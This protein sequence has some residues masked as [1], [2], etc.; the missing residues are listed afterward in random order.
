[1]KSNEVEPLIKLRGVKKHFLKKSSFLEKK[2]AGKKDQTVYAV[3]G[4]NLDIRPKETLSIVGESG[5]GKSTLGRA[6]IRLHEITD[7]KILYRNEDISKFDNNELKSFRQ[8]AQIIFQNPYASLNPRKT[9]REIIQVALQSRGVT[10]F[11]DQ[12]REIISLLDK[13]GLNKR[14]MDNYPHQFSGGQRQRIGIARTIAMNPEFIVADE[15][16]SALDVSVQA[17]IINLLE[18]LKEELDLTYLFVAH[19]LSV[20]HYVSDR[21]AVMYLGEIVELAETKEL[22]NN[23]LHPYTQSLL[24]SIPIVDK[25][26]RIN[27]KERIILTGTVPTPTDAP[28]G[29]KFHTRCFLKIGEICEQVQPKWTEKDGHGAACHLYNE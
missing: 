25:D 5:C 22:F 29:C 4:I 9:V 14:H 23:P 27:A 2:L 20:V 3:D 7:G 11:I 16:V 1:M 6:I 17:Q 24:S 12:E 8:K 10:N 15:P 21:V 13:V 19:D 18:D 26:E 28:K